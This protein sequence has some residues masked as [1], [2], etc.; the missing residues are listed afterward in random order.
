[1]SAPAAAPARR[2]LA[3][4]FSVVIVDLIGFG[5]V[6]PALPFWA[7]EFGADATAL[8]LLMSA[9]AAAQFVF[10]PLW[11]RLSDRVGRRPVLLATIAGTALALLGVGVATSLAWLFVARFLAG[12]FA[13][14]VSVASAY[15]SD[16]TPPEERTRWMGMLGASFGVGFVLGPAI[17][18]LLQ[19]FGHAV[20]M[21][22]AAGL[23]ALNWIFAAAR[24]REPV[25][26]ARVG[27][28]RVGVLRDPAVRRLTLANLL[29]SL[30]VTQLETLFAFFMLDRFAWDMRSVGLVLAGMAVV[31]GG[32]QGGGMKA[33]SAR[34]AERSLVVAGMLLLAL[35]FAALPFPANVPLLLVP[36][37]LA[38]V[39]RAIAQPALQSLASQ[40][41]RPD[42]RGLVLGTFQSSASLARVVGPALGGVLYDVSRPAPFWLASALLLLV[43]LGARALPQGVARGAELPFAPDVS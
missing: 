23:A 34:F 32:I 18:G 17:G 19:P 41:A 26:H 36:L 8:G 5:I 3:V 37:L 22:V 7:R 30:A 35:G 31:M 43:A 15:I 20:P 25:R 10:A 40:A 29:F 4:L 16:V 11:G 28:S 2:G 33:L 21:L 42:Q 13:A 24:L 38:A 27:G 6:M 9:Y 12:A 1:M 39:G 14:N